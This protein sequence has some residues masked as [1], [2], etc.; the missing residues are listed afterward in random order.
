MRVGQKNDL[1][2]R[3]A[4]KG[5]RP[6][7]RK[8]QRYK[9]AYVFGAICPQRGVG[10][11]LIMPYCDTNAMQMHLEEISEQVAPGAHAILVMDRAGWHTTK[12][13]GVPSNMTLLP[14][15][16]RSPE[17]RCAPVLRTPGR[18]PLAVPARSVSLKP[19]IRQ[20]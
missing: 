2:R 7:A 10:A 5:T 8:D 17:P 20:L 12:K 13:L 9:W 6:R 4:K 3:W 18:E 16:P 15:P 14:L 1:T 11:G 19:D